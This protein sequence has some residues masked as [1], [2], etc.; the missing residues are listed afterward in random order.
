[1][2]TA[3]LRI[4]RRL[5]N[6]LTHLGPFVNSSGIDTQASYIYLNNN[7]LMRQNANMIK[8]WYESV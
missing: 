4:H 5:K 7:K 3:N 8:G 6:T 2:Q 1:M